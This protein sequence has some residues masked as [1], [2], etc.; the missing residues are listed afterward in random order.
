MEEPLSM[1][2][3][4]KLCTVRLLVKNEDQ[5]TGFFVAP[6]LILTCAHVVQSAKEKNLPVEV[7][8][9]DGQSLGQGSIEKYLLEK[10]PVK[11]AILKTENSYPD[12]ALL[13]AMQT[14]HPCVFMNHKVS[15]H[16]ELY[17]YGY[18][19][20]YPSGDGVEFT[21]EDISWIDSQRPLLKFREGQA[22]KGLSG[23]PLLNLRTGGVCGVVQNS[24]GS[25]SD[26]GGRAIPT[27]IAW[28]EL[29]EF[30]LVTRQEQYHQ[31]DKRWVESLTPE[32][33]KELGLLPASPATDATGALEVFFSYAREDKAYRDE[34]ATHLKPMQR[35][36]LITSWYDHNTD[37]GIDMKEDAKKHLESARIILMLVSPHYLASDYHYDFE[38]KRA[39]ERE[40]E[41][42]VR[43]IPIMLSNTEGWQKTEFSKLLS[44]P[45]NGKPVKQWGDRDEAYYNIAGEIRRVVEQLPKNS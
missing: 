31:K 22:Q 20:F 26:A 10:I 5:G 44:L 36:G 1:R 2:E 37:A 4:L 42:K 25:E 6:G 8:T 27:D 14:G 24:R 11:D 33:A 32:Q 45:R 43:V 41:G 3:L 39:L 21:Y 30:D 29:K 28:Q 23:A 7:S 40:K 18:T 16:D 13:K 34:L 17:S 38:M 35:E 15:Y 9:W 19:Q 12:L